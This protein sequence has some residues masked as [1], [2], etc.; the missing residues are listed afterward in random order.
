MKLFSNKVRI[1]SFI[2]LY[3]I[4][5]A[6]FAVLSYFAAYKGMVFHSIGTSKNYSVEIDYAYVDLPRMTA[7]L[8]GSSDNVH[9]Q[10]DIA[11][12]VP[13]KDAALLNRYKPRVVDILNRF[14]SGLRPGQLQSSRALPWLRGEIL[15]QVNDAELPVP[16]HAI[17]VQRLI[18]T[19]PP[20]AFSHLVISPHA[21]T[22]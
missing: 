20:V 14:F 7:S 1:P 16:V 15:K 19:Q 5:F 4:I 18:V 6:V 11:L 3:T 9:M 13:K 10:I 22:S 2:V 12:E 21:P 8:N 17:W